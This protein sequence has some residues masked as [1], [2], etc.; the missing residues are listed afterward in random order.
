MATARAD[1][2][3]ATSTVVIAGQAS[4]GQSRWGLLTISS[5]DIDNVAMSLYDIMKNQSGSTGKYF[6]ND[7]TPLTRRASINFKLLAILLT[8]GEMPL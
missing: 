8:M 1:C 5:P 3:L 6:T 4:N 2:S 7:N